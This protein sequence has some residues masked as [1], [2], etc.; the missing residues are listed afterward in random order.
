MFSSIRDARTSLNRSSGVARTPRPALSVW[1]LACTGGLLWGGCLM[2]VGT[3]HHIWPTYGTAFL[4]VLRSV[5]PGYGAA[6]GSLGVLIGTFYGA[7]DGAVAGALVAWLY[8]AVAAP[9]EPIARD[10]GQPT[11]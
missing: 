2:V 6:T 11:M 1:G 10:G 9:A 4:D 5:Y 7:V 8:N 3:C